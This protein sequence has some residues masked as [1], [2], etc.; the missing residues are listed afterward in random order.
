MEKKLRIP[1]RLRKIQ[2]AQKEK[3]RQEKIEKYWQEHQEEK[4]ALD[5]EQEDIRK[6]LEELKEKI[7][8]IDNANADKLEELY[9]EKNRLLPCEE[10]VQ[11]QEDVIRALEKKRQ[12]CGLFQGKMKQEIVT[13]IDQQEEPKLKELKIQAAAEKKEHQER[14]DVEINVL[15]RDGKEFR[16][17]FAKLKKREQE[18]TQELTKE[19]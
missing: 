1:E 10:A 13:Q 8:A 19:R 16:D 18:I 5:D 17:Q 2:A 7:T 11:K 15:K 3:K 12:K 6:K 14:I 9:S 4:R